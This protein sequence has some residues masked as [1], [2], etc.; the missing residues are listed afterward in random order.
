MEVSNTKI[1]DIM[2]SLSQSPMSMLPLELIDEIIM[3]VKNCEDLKELRFTNVFLGD[4]IKNI[5]HL[6]VKN[7]LSKNPQEAHIW[8]KYNALHTTDTNL[9]Y[10][11]FIQLCRESKI[12]RLNS[13]LAPYNFP[14]DVIEKSINLTNDNLLLD[15]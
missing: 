11:N 1:S 8:S 3:N 14:A 12:F 15:L 4:R 6:V 5:I 9:N 10:K 7:I 13:Y 2:D